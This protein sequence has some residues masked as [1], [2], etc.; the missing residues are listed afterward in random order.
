[1]RSAHSRANPAT[2]SAKIMKPLFLRALVVSLLGFAMLASTAAQG[3][4]GKDAA[5][6]PND[7]CLMC[8]TE[9]M[10]ADSG[11]SI[12]VDAKRFAA[13]V[14][15]SMQL[16]CTSCHADVA[17]D[18][19]PHGTLKPAQ[20]DSCHEKAVKE[21]AATAHGKARADGKQVAA[22]CSNCHG[23]HDILKTSDPASRTSHDNLEQTC[24]ACHGN[25]ALIR[26]ANLPGGNI[27]SRY[28]DSIHGQA[29]ANKTAAKNAAPT[30]TN[31][32]GAH[33]L[34]GKSDPASRVARANIPGTCGSCHMNVKA[35]WEKSQHGKMRQANV[36]Q[37]PGCTD[38]H[39][40][41]DIKEHKHPQWTVELTKE[42]GNCHT[43]YIASYRDTFHGQVN[44]LG[45]AQ[46][47]TC[48]SC[49]GSH[50]ILPA[51]D[52]ASK[53]S[54]QN[55]LATCQTCHAKAN[56]N[57]ALYDPHANRRSPERGQLLFYTGKFMDVLLIGVFSFFGLHTILWFFRSLKAVREERARRDDAGH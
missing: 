29:I 17:P 12:A 44:E 41:H 2:S 16:P 45:F 7:A 6:G 30:C 32:H 34:R 57:F 1:L 22:T 11:K 31:C 10:K 54:P 56:A 27:A 4:T 28:H 15:G 52:P 20:C 24:A 38:C 13:S 21:Y 36:L 51:S 8:H 53:V 14:H 49:H 26:K 48:A 47:A 39:S 35:T 55:R 25:E 46:M 19:I 18:K 9:G 42:C 50:E 40:A 23:N 3:A 37:A 5:A 43:D 33:D